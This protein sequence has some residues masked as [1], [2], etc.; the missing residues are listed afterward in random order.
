MT[1][2]IAPLVAFLLPALA[3]LPA[4]A[5]D[6]KGTVA[7]KGSSLDVKYAYLVQTTDAMSN[8][9]MRRV[10]LSNKDIGAKIASCANMS[11]VDGDLGE[12]LE[13]DFVPGP[14]L[15]YWLVMNG[16]KVQY[17]GTE[18]KASFTATSDDAKKVAG[19]LRFD[20]TSAGGPKVDVQFDAALVKE[21]K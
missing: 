21:L 4:A 7:Y 3:A 10:V 9:P 19:T 1:R 5:G 20:K 14:R 2:R 8:A 18:P 6:A 17:S 12:G 16:Q 11:C 13:V 15:N